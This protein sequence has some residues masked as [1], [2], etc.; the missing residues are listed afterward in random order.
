MTCG[1]GRRVRNR[2][3][4]DPPA[5]NGGRECGGHSEEFQDCDS[6][7]CPGLSN[8]EAWTNTMYR[9]FGKGAIELSS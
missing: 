2:Y 5:Q 6:G 1:V 9:S 3:C 4:N 8:V 7:P